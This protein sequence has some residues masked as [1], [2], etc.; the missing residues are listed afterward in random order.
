M[1]KEA[2]KDAAEADVAVEAD[3]II[4]TATAPAD[5]PDATTKTVTVCTDA[6]STPDAT[7][8]KADATKH[9]AKRALP[10]TQPHPANATVR[11]TESVEAN[12]ASAEADPMAIEKVAEASPKQPLPMPEISATE[13]ASC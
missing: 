6:T 4:T 10:T 11:A 1:V 13:T 12:A 7:L 2:A 8:P 5:M 3:A 9:A